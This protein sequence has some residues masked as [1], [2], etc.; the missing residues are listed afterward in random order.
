MD[1]HPLVFEAVTLN[2]G[3][4]LDLQVPAHCAVSIV[5]AEDSGVGCLGR[6]ALGLERPASGKVLV[7]GEEIGTMARRHALAFRRRVGYLPA[8]DGLLQNLS[9]YDNIALPLRFGTSLSER[10]I[11]GRMRIMVTM[12]GIGGV[13]QHRPAAVNEEQRRRAALARALALNPSLVILEQPFDGLTVA[14]AAELL[15]LARGG[16]T[17]EGSMRTVFIVGQHLPEILRR[18]IEFCYR[19]GRSGLEREN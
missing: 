10:E 12:V 13:A 8:G 17:A 1:G 2:H 11:A 19:L 18:R 14:A 9:L 16:E 3:L 6:Y 5:G 7:L 15:E 4:T